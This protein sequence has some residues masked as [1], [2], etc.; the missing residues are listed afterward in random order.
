MQHFSKIVLTVIIAVNLHSTCDC[1]TICPQKM[2][3]VHRDAF[4]SDHH[5]SSADSLDRLN[6]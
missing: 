3:E 6:R 1:T 2:T 4:V 5:I